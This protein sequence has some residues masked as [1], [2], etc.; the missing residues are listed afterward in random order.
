MEQSSCIDIHAG[1]LETSQM[2]INY[3]DLVDKELASKLNPTHIA[4]NNMKDL[5]VG[6]DTTKKLVPEGY[7]SDPTNIDI[8]QA[9]LY[10]KSIVDDIVLSIIN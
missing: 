3:S 6:G 1:S 9:K 2:I 5:F 7:C 8:K 4:P 10:E